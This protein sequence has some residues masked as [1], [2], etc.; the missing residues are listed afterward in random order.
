MSEISFD[1]MFDALKNNTK[2]I[3]KKIVNKAN[4]TV[5]TAKI[6]YAI[7]ETEEKIND[8]KAL[9]GGIIYNEYLKS[10]DFEGQ[11]GEYCK[12]IENFYDDIEIMEKKM[13]EIKSSVRCANCGAFN[14]A[15][16]NFCATCGDKL[17]N[18]E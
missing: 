1:D 7:S 10:K 4:E 9:I 15:D 14:S 11:I 13:A 2:R 16:K 8:Y 3:S 18:E 12:A 17:N 5:E 6:K